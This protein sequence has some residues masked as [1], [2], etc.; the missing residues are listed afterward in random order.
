MLR[1]ATTGSLNLITGSFYVLEE[2]LRVL[3][4]QQADQPRCEEAIR[5]L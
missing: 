4:S 2:A 1:N 5:A 3:Q